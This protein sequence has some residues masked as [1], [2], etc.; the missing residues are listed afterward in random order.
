MNLTSDNTVKEI[1]TNQGLSKSYEPR[2]AETKWR[3]FWINSRLGE[4]KKDASLPSFSLVI[5]PP[6]VTGRLHM[7]HALVQTVQDI[8]VRFER[9]RGKNAM[10]VPGT[11]HA[12]ISTQIIVERHLKQQGLD[13]SNMTREEFLTHCWKW[14]E[15]YETSILDQVRLLGGSC[16]WSMQ[17]FTMDAPRSQAV[18]TAFK[19]LYEK[20]L[21]YRGDYLVNWDYV[22]RTALSDDEVEY[23]E[24]QTFLWHMRYPV[25]SGGFIEIATTRPETMLGDTAVAVHPDDPRYQDFVGK[26]VKLPLS[27]REVPIIADAFV[28]PTFGTGAVKITPAHDPNDYQMAFRHQLPMINIFCEDGTLNTEAGSYAGL[29]FEKAREVIA[30]DL[31]KLGVLIKV[32]PYTTRVGVSYRSKAVIQPLLSKQWFFKLSSFKK[33]LREVVEKGR[34]EIVPKVWES[35]YYHW[36]D[37]LR[38]WCISRQL[39]WGHRIPVWHRKDGSCEPICDDGEEIPAE[40]AANP[41]KWQQDPDVLDTWFSSSLWPLSVMGWPKATLELNTF[42]PTNVLVTGHDILFFWVARMML[43]CELMQGE[44]P[45]SKVYLTGLIFGKSYWREQPGGGIAYVTPQERLSFDTGT[46]LPK[47]VLSRWEK[48]SKTKGNVIDPIEIID[49]YGADA[50]RMA[51]ASSLGDARQIDLDRRKFEEFKNFSN[52]LFNS[53]RFVFMNLDQ[54]PKLTPELFSH[55]LDLEKLLT[56]DRWIIDTYQITVKKVESNLQ[57]FEFALAA[58]QAYSFFWDDFCAYYLEISKPVLWGKAMTS[59]H[60]LNKQKLLTIVLCGSLRLFHPFTPFITEELMAHLRERLLPVPCKMDIDALTQEA[61]KA[62]QSACCMVSSYPQC[63]SLNFE[64]STHQMQ[65]LKEIIYKV[66][67]LRGEM[68]I[69]TGSPTDL[70]INTSKSNSHFVQTHEYVLRSLLP[71]KYIRYNEPLSGDMLAS[72]ATIADITLTVPLPLEM[73]QAEINRLH[74]QRLQLDQNIELLTARLASADF[75]AK[76]PAQL[77]QKQRDQLETFKNERHA[78]MDQ[79]HSL[80]SSL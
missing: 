78:I 15:E 60:R 68:K 63:S 59:E 36:I 30:D 34:V 62:L 19:R 13:R 31:K 65:I 18:R 32:E 20:G 6:N 10:W 54:E 1:D 73:A 3:A 25:I 45:F 5:P 75:V 37:N 57:Q 33:Q 39:W 21:I 38:D 80:G 29:H 58:E 76:A 16:D 27:G 53:A 28:D 51:L 4:A 69:L 24:R 23:E 71:L 66:R 41:E 11:D 12:G 40:V 70:F 55:G 49:S 64:T 74:K 7:G 46:P 22:S 48:M 67:Q 79:L 14:K 9:M 8:L 35:T 50:M 77:V 17:A 43:M 42:Y 52:K 61:C 2:L 56:E 47:N 44:L 26:F 72:K